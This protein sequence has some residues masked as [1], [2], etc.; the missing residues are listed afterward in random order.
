MTFLPPARF[1][2]SLSQLS[3]SRCLTTASGSAEDKSGPGVPS[4]SGNSPNTAATPTRPSLWGHQASDVTPMLKTC[5]SIL[6]IQDTP[7]GLSGNPT[8]SLWP[9]HQSQ[10]HQRGWGI[11]WE[12]LWYMHSER[13]RN[14]PR[15]PQQFKDLLSLNTKN[16]CIKNP[17]RLRTK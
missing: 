9:H 17:L 16:S 3:Q 4:V 13:K 2:L 12:H 10:Q 7:Q 14:I 15:K 5:F 8:A 1:S 6:K 11:F